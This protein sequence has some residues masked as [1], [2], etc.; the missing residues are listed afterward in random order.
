M[1]QTMSCGDQMWFVVYSR[2]VPSCSQ[3]KCFK[4]ERGILNPQIRQLSA[5]T[6]QFNQSL[7]RYQNLKRFKRVPN[8]EAKQNFDENSAFSTRYSRLSGVLLR[9]FLTSKSPLQFQRF[10]V[11]ISSIWTTGTFGELTRYQFVEIKKTL[12]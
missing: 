8:V 10:I 12:Y 7:V 5:S 1:L 11:N 9:I 2:I 6:S 4:N 3:S